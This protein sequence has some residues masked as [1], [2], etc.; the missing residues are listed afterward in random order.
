MRK[1]A[2]NVAS[3]VEQVSIPGR[4]GRNG[5][6]DF[7]LVEL[8]LCWDERW[9]WAPY[10]AANIEL[11]DVSKPDDCIG[12]MLQREPPR[13]AAYIAS[14]QYDLDQDTIGVRIKGLDP[15]DV[16][17]TLSCLWKK[18]AGDCPKPRLMSVEEASRR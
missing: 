7:D 12:Q 15:P 17:V 18:K 4:S 14:V 2:H 9:E 10:S 3:R 6:F 11:P 8:F 1:A 5:T 16:S 13:P